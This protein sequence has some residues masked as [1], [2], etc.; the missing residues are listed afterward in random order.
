MR[1]IFCVLAVLCVSGCG[2]HAHNNEHAEKHA[3]KNQS[4]SPETPTNRISVNELVRRNLG[5]TFATVTYRPIA[6]TVRVPGQLVSLPHG[7]RDFHA[8]LAGKITLQIALHQSV[9]A[10]TVMYE[11]D[12]PEWR[13]LQ[14]E[15]TDKQ[16]AVTQADARLS[17]IIAERAQAERQ[18]ASLN[19][20]F[21]LH[22]ERTKVL[23]DTIA[24]W[25]ERIAQLEQ[26]QAAG[27]GR[28]SE[29]TEARTRLLSAINERA[30]GAEENAEHMMEHARL[31]AALNRQGDAPA[32]FTAHIHAART[33]LSSAKTALWLGLQKASS[34]SGLS[35]EQLVENVDVPLGQPLAPDAGVVPR[36]Q[37]MDRLA[38]VAGQTGM[39]SAIQVE[40]GAWVE[41]NRPL[42]R[43]VDPTAVRFTGAL[44]QKDLARIR[45]GQTVR[46]AGPAGAVGTAG[47]TEELVGKLLLSPEINATSRTVDIS[48]LPN[49][50]VAW[51]RPGLS[52]TAD[53]IT[54]G[55]DEALVIP[56][57]AVV[58]DTLK[59]VIFRRDPKNPDQVIYLEADLGISDGKFIA[60]ES[61]LREGDEVVVDGAYEL[62]L[63]SGGNKM[64]GH[65]HADGTWHADGH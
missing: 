8:P 57:Q 17:Q 16:L 1:I 51:A 25:R 62:V 38:I 14:K 24:L 35:V 49:N 46:I 61:G 64:G 60:V 15:L 54:A 43:L 40:N 44:L 13:S 48:V 29:L 27:G 37:A 18:L 19:T 31:D 20:L 56:L 45:A 30:A 7:A 2:D 3:E 53:I 59:K 6:Q 33:E 63:H 5:I 42:A 22:K 23:D 26:V 52:T 21:P 11:L 50:S 65:F 34:L 39:I 28:A 10:Q 32:Y 41:A 36:W 9:T 58:Q 47:Q 4:A 55:G 12:A